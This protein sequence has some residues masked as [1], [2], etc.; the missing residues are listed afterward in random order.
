MNRPAS[1]SKIEHPEQCG[2]GGDEV[3]ACDPPELAAEALGVGVVELDQARHV[4]EPDH[5]GDDHGGER[6]LGKVLEEPRQEEQRD[7][8]EARR[9]ER[10]E[11]RAGACG[12]VDGGLGEA[13]ADD[14]AA[15]QAGGEVG[16]AESDQFAVGVD[17]LVLA[18]AV[19]LGR[20]ESL[21]ER[22]EHHADAARGQS[23]DVRQP[24]VGHAQ[25]W[26]PAAD[27]PDDG[28]IEAEHLHRANPSGDGHQRAGDAGG[29]PAQANDHRQ[30]Q[31]SH[32]QCERLRVAQVGDQVPGLL[33]EVARSPVQ[34]EQLGQLTDED[35]EREA[36]DE[37]LEHRL[38]DEVGQ[39]P[40]AQEARNHGSDTGDK[41][42]AGR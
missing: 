6:R 11:L 4:D 27:R 13:A 40:Q 17:A 1:V 25:R 16:A 20:C 30:R 7:H 37:A 18:R 39:E 5:R 41:R 3:G 21:R 24:D 32:E 19:G 31:R 9:D 26:Q 29:E 33:E 8:G 34:P 10:R 28:H 23:A 36:D 12:R 14:H 38:A 22:D 2:D 35:R 42:Q 15:G